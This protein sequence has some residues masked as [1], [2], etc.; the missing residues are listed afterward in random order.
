MLSPSHAPQPRPSLRR[1]EL[2]ALALL[3]LLAA[4][5]RLAWLDQAAFGF[6][7]AR[8]SGLALAMARGGQLATTGMQSSVGVPNL[9][10]TVWVF[11]LF[12]RLSADPLHATAGVALLNALGVLGLGWMA[13]RAWGSLAGLTAAALWAASPWAIFFSRSIW[14]QDLLPPLAIL[15][16]C[17]GLLAAERRSA[18]WLAA[19]LFLAGLAPQIHYAGLALWPGSLWLLVR[20]GLWRRGWALA[21]G[22]TGALLAA[23]PFVRAV[24]PLRHTILA[25]LRE[26]GGGPVQADLL[27]WQHLAHMGIGAHWQDLLAG[28]RLPWSPAV[29]AV[30]EAALWVMGAW[31]A[32]GFGLL[33]WRALRRGRPADPLVGLTLSWALAAPLLF[34]LRTTPVYHHYTLVALPAL[35][36][37]VAYAAM[38]AARRPLGRALLATLLIAAL[39]QAGLWVHT[40]GWLARHTDGGQLA[41]QWPRA[42]VRALD[43]DLPVVIYADCDWAQVCEQAAIWDVLLWGRD[44]RTI[45]ARQAL[46]LPAA[47]AERGAHMIV[48]PSAGQAWDALL[49]MGWPAESSRFL[50]RGEFASPYRMMTVPPEWP[51]WL[52]GWIPVEPLTLST[53]AQL[54]AWRAQVQGDQVLLETL[55]YVSGPIATGQYQ[56]FNHL[57][58]DGA[59]VS[60]QDGS[61]SIRAW[62]PGDWLVTRA[63]LAAPPDAREL[64]FQVGM[65]AWPELERALILER[66]KD[67]ERAIRLGP[68]GA[69]RGG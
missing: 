67:A 38:W 24:W 14:A 15:W 63:T 9:P 59:K 4:A 37:A 7:Q 45:D 30:Y 13:R 2:A 10:A 68:L 52:S 51:T 41:L 34:T 3:A 49:G 32:A 54:H 20:H 16:A 19:H 69:G 47:A 1:I 56:Q 40:A 23:A 65:Y 64:S 18:G 31:L 43:D 58:A 11:A 57:Y 61:V 26:M 25:Q 60:G 39:A 33:L 21:A 42:V 48:T 12:Y 62:Q 55:W 22:A 50:A 6:D 35:A 27:P 66:P 53:G 29:G 8:V 17:C 44:H 28:D 5:L 46:L 36:L